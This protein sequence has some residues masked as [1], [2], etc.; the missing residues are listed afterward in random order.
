MIA[1]GDDPIGDGLEHAIRSA[2]PYIDE[3]AVWANGPETD[4]VLTLLERLA[5]EP[6][7]PIVVERGAWTDDFSAARAASFAMTRADWILYL[8]CNDT[9]RGG[10]NLCE[11]IERAGRGS[12]VYA[13]YDT[14]SWHWWPRIVRR[15]SGRW[16]GVVHERWRRADRWPGWLLGVGARGSVWAHPARLSVFHRD[17]QPDQLKY[18]GALAAAMLDPKRTPWAAWH[19]ARILSGIDDHRSIELDEAS[20]ANGW[21]DYEGKLNEYR[22]DSLYRLARVCERV[23]RLDDAAR[24]H[25]EWDAYSQKVTRSVGALAPFRYS[26]YSQTAVWASMSPETVDVLL[27]PPLA[28]V[29]AAPVGATKVGRNDPCPCRSGRKYKRCCGGV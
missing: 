12:T 7:A 10:E 1:G 20:L 27:E 25:A 24:W 29:S 26:L 28:A 4:A 8:D 22:A 15:G 21:T 16:M 14:C 17:R 23:G 5:A 3:V 2:R 9:L 11:I 6:G 19:L 18:L 13:A